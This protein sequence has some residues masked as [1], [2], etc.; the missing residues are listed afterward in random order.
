MMLLG[1][2]KWMENGNLVMF[3]QGG[4]KTKRSE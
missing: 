3:T 1:I 2:I 4:M